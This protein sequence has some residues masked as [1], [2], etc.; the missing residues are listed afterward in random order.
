MGEL[1]DRIRKTNDIRKIAPEDY[2]RLA[3]EIRGFLVR[4]ISRRGG[5]LASNLGAVELT[6]ALHLVFDP[7]KDRLIFDVGHQCYTHKLLTGRKAEFDH[8]R[9]MGGLSGFPKRA[10]SPAD[11]FDTGHSS[12]S[13]SMGLGLAEARDI[14]GEHY[15]VVSVIGD[16]SMTGGLAF[17]ALNNASRL[18]SNYIIVLNDNNMSISQNI[19]GLSKALRALRTA[20]RYTRLKDSVKKSLG[21]IPD[22]GE[23]VIS[24]VDRM[25][26]SM[27]QLVMPNMLFEDLGLTYLGP[28]DGHDVTAI[29]D[30]LRDARRVNKAVIVHVVTKKGKG[31]PYAEKNPEQYHGV[32][33]FDPQS[34]K[35]L[36]EKKRSYTDV[37]SEMLLRL[38]SE[39]PHLY[40]VTAAMAAGTG[41]TAFQKAFPER[42]ADVGIA[43][44]HAL[45]F[46][47][48]LARGGMKPYVCLY[49][50]FLQRAYDQLIHDICLQKAKVT[51]LVDRAGL[52]GADGETHQGMM[53]VSFLRS[54]PGMTL[55]APRDGR[56]L[57]EMLRFS[58]DF[59]GPLAIRYPR[60]AVPEETEEA[61]R[62]AM[63]YGK[64]EL[65]EKGSETL[66]WAAGSMTE[67][68]RELCARL[69]AAGKPCTL[70]NARFLKPLDEG[71]L[72]ELAGS[73]RRILV[74]SE[75]NR[76]G[77]IGEAIA[78]FSAAK[79]LSWEVLFGEPE[80]S[81]VPQGSPAQLK[82]LLGMDA[83]TLFARLCPEEVDK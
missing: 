5:H 33:P 48:G 4:K 13:I 79:G 80:D 70:V 46:A 19:G 2:P 20:P 1:L 24:G 58:V 9:E 75:N 51:L 74:L 35:C 62:A 67:T 76:S 28:V 72:T 59:P 64:A 11:V 53:D 18:K 26:N 31:V 40:T 14:S 49:S 71:L 44:A 65:L 23:R 41:L 16:G 6:M 55:M 39:E 45:S 69:R 27:K 21:K 37:A 34:G 54:C 30:C 77:G 78:A 83:E 57:E 68:G 29:A 10:E 43:E 56:E 50:S 15:A 36:E 32:G 8:L 17:E 61:E 52:V 38:G 66:I 82:T 73:H 22:V 12:T 42:F 63:V 3:R 60:G 25:K 7:E 81:F 47:S